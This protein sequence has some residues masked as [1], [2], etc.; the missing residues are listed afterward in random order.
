MVGNPEQKFDETFNGEFDQ[1]LQD[2]CNCKSFNKTKRFVNDYMTQVD[3][4]NYK[5]NLQSSFTKDDFKIFYH[6]IKE[7]FRTKGNG[8]Y[9][10]PKS[11]Q[12]LSRDKS[13]M[14]RLGCTEACYRCGALCWSSQNHHLNS[15]ITKLHHTSHQPEGLKGVGYAYTHDL[16]AMQC[17]KWG[18][19]QLF[20]EMNWQTWAQLKAELYSDWK[21]ELHCTQHFND[22]MCWFFE[23]L[24]VDLAKTKNVNPAT[25]D[26]L[27][28]NCCINLDYHHIISILRTISL[29]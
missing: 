27:R 23:K 3:K 20:G 28:R 6:T 14:E 2:I 1:V 4:I 8:H 25:Y 5:L 9:L 22:L 19:D 21:F 18:V 13:V 29:A 16:I 17:H 11:F 15:D 10:K 26:E 12:K 7:E 24:H